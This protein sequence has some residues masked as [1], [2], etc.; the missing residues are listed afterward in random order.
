MSKKEETTFAERV[1]RD[2]KKVFGPLVF[3][4]NIQQVV[5]VG[6]PDRLCCINGQFV[7]LE[8]KVRGGVLSKVQ[9]LK[10]ARI[11]KAGGLAFVVYPDT[12]E[13]IIKELKTLLN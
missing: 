11:K 6:T 3:F 13:S 1:D 7:A 2:L 9:Y 4:E 10:L 8:L 5:K 12:W